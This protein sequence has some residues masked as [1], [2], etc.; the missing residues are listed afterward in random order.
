MLQFFLPQIVS[1]AEAK[2]TPT[3]VAKIIQDTLDAQQ[4]ADLKTLLRSDAWFQTLVDLHRPV[5]TWPRWFA[6]LRENLI[7]SA[8]VQVIEAE[9]VPAT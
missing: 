8:K 1:M 6:R 9:T 3:D 2:Q 4:L 7:E 5:M